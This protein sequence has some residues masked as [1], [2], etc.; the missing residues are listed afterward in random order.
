[1]EQ[2]TQNLKDGRMQLLEVP[3]PA[4]SSGC[5]LVRNHYSLISA[6]T[7]G[8]TVKDAR[9]G[10]FAKARS[11]KEEVRKVVEAARTYGLRDTYRMVMNKLTSPSPLGYS[12]AGEV[13]GIASDV[14]DFRVGDLVACGG[15]MANHAEV[16]SVPVN[17]CVKIDNSVPLE[18]AAFT[19]LGA[20]ALQGI[21]QA[22]LRLGENCVVIG[23]GL[24]GQLSMQMLRAAGVKAIG[25]DTDQ[26][27]VNLARKNGFGLS[28]LRGRED[29]EQLVLHESDGHG[30]DS[31]IITAGTDSTDPVDLA[32]LLA[33]KKGKVVVV[34]AV[35]TGFKRENYFKK[36]LDLRM[37]SSYGPGRYDSEYEEQGIDY[38]YAYVRWTENRN[39]QA[40]AE[41]LKSGGVDLSGLLT[42]TFPFS[43]APDAYQLILDRNEPYAGIVLKYD[44]QKNI[45]R[46]ITLRART[47]SSGSPVIGLIGAGSFAQN[48]L[49]PS[50]K[51]NANLHTVVTGR[52]QNARNIADKFGFDNCSGDSAE[53]FSNS[54]INTVFIATRHDS[55]A[56]YVLQALRSGKNVFVEKP[57]C[58]SP[59]DLEEIR[60]EYE[61]SGHRLM[62]GFNRRFAPLLTE[63]KNQMQG[64]VPLAIHYRINAG[65]IPK[66]H[67][68]QDLKTGGGRILGE[69]CHFVD[70][71]AFI[72]SS[73]IRSLNAS[74]MKDASGLNDTVAITLNFINGSIAQISYFSNGSKNLPK[75]K[76]EV[77]GSGKVCVLDDFKELAIT[78]RNTVRK[79]GKQDKG[80]SAEVKLFLDS[81]RNN[82]A[83]PIPFTEIYSA[84]LATFKILESA[85]TGGALIEL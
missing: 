84:T 34:G 59:E 60:E 45:Y 1:M 67:W 24:L 29:L 19:T 76:L 53:I 18:Y 21:R 37:S 78:G 32:G 6:G 64:P 82:T 31:V 75:E 62:V 23:L 14:T 72:A 5:V 58:L 81:I 36:E 2:L 61:R 35:P 11:R 41:M 13:I 39:M 28:F 70:L 85:A 27:M 25:I 44:P 46:S 73:E 55:H 69:V 63:L 3:F 65:I 52:P 47:Y 42:H 26:N 9:L 57:L 4:L 49:L 50:L 79:T 16:V 30:C 54:E 20:I 10:L 40:F 33:R 15:S 51:G 77:Y 22:D 56:T 48:F 43:D 17:L 66:D 74:I 12:C 8:K 83:D 68:T 80:H 38:P 7:E 71:C